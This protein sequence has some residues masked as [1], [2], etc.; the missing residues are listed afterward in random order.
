MEG[1]S[2]LMLCRPG[3]PQPSLGPSGFHTCKMTDLDWY[4]CP[5]VSTP[6]EGIWKWRC[7]PKA[8]GTLIQEL[9]EVSAGILPALSCDANYTT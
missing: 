7:L 4:F 1:E 9:E 2:Q 3:H 5:G 8:R 6:Q